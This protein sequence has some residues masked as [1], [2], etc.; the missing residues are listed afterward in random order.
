MIDCVVVGG[1]AAGLAASAALGQHGVQ[2]VVLEA[3]QA[4]QTWATQRW[5]SFRLNTPGWTNRLLGDQPHAAYLTA[6]EVVDRLAV[7]AA[8]APIRTAVRV[9]NVAQAGTGFLLRTSDEE[10]RARTVVVA[11]GDENIPRTPPVAA[12]LPGSITQLHSAEYRN[13][14]L[15][16][17]GAVLVVGSGQSGAQ[18]SEDLLVAG[19]RVLLATSPVGHVPVRHRGYDSFELLHAGGFFDQTP[20]DLPD[21]ALMRATQPILAPGGKPLSLR[22]LA[23]AGATL[24]G[25]MVA[26]DDHRVMFD[27]STEPN[28]AA[29]EAFAS[30]VRAML[31]AQIARTDPTSRPSR[32]SEDDES[33][34]SVALNPPASVKLSTLAAVVWCTG[35]TSDFSWLDT[36]LL[37]L[38]GRPRHHGCAGS[39]P[40]LWYV[41]LR[42]LTHRS[43]ATLPGIPKDAAT[44]AAAVAAH[45]HIT[46]R[47]P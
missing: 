33:D 21:P 40:G 22:T 38:S 18:I 4:G 9:M 5:N 19:R 6:G 26:V 27:D 30:Y 10:I 8:R 46:R 2:H 41:G 44:V 25:R 12:T 43:S 36:A 1:G 14:G 28:V 47:D 45:L 7:L 29:G 37:D 24:T 20:A 13:P 15:L 3:G 35:F 34:V 11:T 31:D 17:D 39:S 32:T 23:R 16:P 42:W